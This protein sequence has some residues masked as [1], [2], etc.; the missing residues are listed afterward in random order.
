MNS[1]DFHNAMVANEIIDAKRQAYL[2]HVYETERAKYSSPP[3][4]V[5]RVVEKVVQVPQNNSDI[6][7]RLDKMEAVI[8]KMY[9]MFGQMANSSTEAKFTNG[10]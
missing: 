4:T 9:E 6:Y 10:K 8:E 7:K 2:D 5:T 1:T 3:R